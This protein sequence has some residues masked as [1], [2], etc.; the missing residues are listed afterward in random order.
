MSYLLLFHYLNLKMNAIYIE[1]YLY[2]SGF[3]SVKR[4]ENN[5]D[6]NQ[7]IFQQLMIIFYKYN[8]FIIIDKT[9]F[10]CL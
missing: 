9:A 1:L 7:I 3:A 2:N 8:S 6:F 5:P 10:E 4:F